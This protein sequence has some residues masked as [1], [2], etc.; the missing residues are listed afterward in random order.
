[1]NGQ[2]LVL[3][4]GFGGF[5]AL[6][7]LRYYHG[8]TEVLDELE[9]ELETELGDPHPF[10]VHFFP[11]LPTASVQTRA[12]QLQLWLTELW[13]RSIIRDQDSIH[14]IGHSTGG[15][16]LRQLL[17]DY[18]A[19][20]GARRTGGLPPV[21]DRIASV[22]FLSTPHRGTALAHHLGNTWWR[23]A[24]C[25][26]VLSMLYEGTYRLRER[27]AGRL[28]QL[29]KVLMPDQVTAD[30]IDA[31]V[32]TLRGCSSTRDPLQQAHARSAYFNLMRWLRDMAEDFAA[33]TDLD[34]YPP[35]RGATSFSPAHRNEAELEE[36][37]ALLRE[38]GIR[39]CSIVTMARAPEKR[40]SPEL[41]SVLYLLT[42]YRPPERLQPL[43]VPLRWQ[44]PHSRMLAPSENDGLVNSV[45]QV[46]PTPQESFLVEADHADVIGHF[47]SSPSAGDGD[48]FSFRQYDLLDSPSGFDNEAFRE[49]WKHIG[50]FALQLAQPGA[51]KAEKPPAPQERWPP[52]EEIHQH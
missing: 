16:D 46:W 38:Q 43:A 26:S 14:L 8:V 6:G 19:Q 41:Y 13:K 36:E 12:R 32:D 44:A 23:R 11:N 24:L 47:R 25:K 15:L 42:S 48:S 21:L 39:C 10:T 4:P 20:R 5:D 33:I 17:I 40:F 30:W 45:S 51:P 22:Q 1:M 49:L 29:L 35:R 52:P 31:F 3:V 28:G 18:Q 50:R 37:K 7:S 9:E 2:H 34:S 27:G